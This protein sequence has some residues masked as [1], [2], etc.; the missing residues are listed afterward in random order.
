MRHNFRGRYNLIID[1]KD[2]T[3]LSAEQPVRFFQLCPSEND[4]IQ[5][6]VHVTVISRDLA[7]PVFTRSKYEI[8]TSEDILPGSIVIANLII[9]ILKYKESDL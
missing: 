3:G 4:Q 9:I 8:H 1:A 5:A 2:G 7:T 6:Q